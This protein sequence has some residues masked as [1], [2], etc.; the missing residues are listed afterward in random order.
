MI[1]ALPRRRGIAESLILWLRGVRGLAAIGAV[2]AGGA[3]AGSYYL[4][5]DHGGSTPLRPPSGRATRANIWVSANG[6]DSGSH[7]VRSASRV[8]NPDSGGATL[9]QSFNKAYALS[10]PGGDTV[11]VVGSH[12]DYGSQ[13]ILRESHSQAGPVTRFICRTK[14]NCWIGGFLALGQN[15]GGTANGDNDAPSYLAFS[16]INIKNGCFTTYYQEPNPAQ[17]I[18]NAP[19][20]TQLSFSNAHITEPNGACH[21]LNLNSV[22]HFTAKNVELGPMCCGGDAVE[23]GIP[24][25]GA[26]R[27]S[28]ITLDGLYVHDI[29]DSCTHEQAALKARHRC[30]STGYGDNG[31]GDHVDGIQAFG[32]M[33]CRVENSRWYAINPTSRTSTGAAQAIFFQTANCTTTSFPD[34]L[35]FKDLTFINN[36]VSCGCGTVAFGLSVSAGIQGTYGGT[37]KFLY[38]TVLSGSI[39]IRDDTTLK[40]LAAGTR[41]VYVGNIAKPG[42]YNGSTNCSWVAVDGATI[43]PTARNNVAS[44]CAGK[45]NISGPASFVSSSYYRPDLRL[46]GSQAAI[47][48]GES[49]YCGSGKD[50]TTDLFGTQRPVSS[51]CDIGAQEA[52]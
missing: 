47:N 9:C 7:C 29:Y 48:G 33:T 30:I 25:I 36:L 49:T 23:L 20:P 1:D 16:G 43:T 31:Q 21:M 50:V 28:N 3:A 5:Q 34:G 51:A 24:R 22:D 19:Q 8:V 45:G 40:A 14:N 32:C 15:S 6:S 44:N 2:V 17:G 35:C 18:P 11:G 27:P 26:P 10:A 4:Y 12:G 41:V 13:T 38:N 42:H 39:A 37:L 46:S 52:R